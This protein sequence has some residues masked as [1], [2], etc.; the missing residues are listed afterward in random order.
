MPLV[1]ILREIRR[2]QVKN[3]LWMG[4]LAVGVAGVLRMI[5]DGAGGEVASAIAFQT[6]AI[7]FGFGAV[8]GRLDKPPPPK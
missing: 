7:L 2:P 8:M 6:A 3:V 4:A 1:G 5:Q